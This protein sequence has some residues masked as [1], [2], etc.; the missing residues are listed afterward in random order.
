MPSVTSVMKNTV[1]PPTTTGTRAR[2]VI[3]ASRHSGLARLVVLLLFSFQLACGADPADSGDGRN[4][5]PIGIPYMVVSGE[6]LRVPVSFLH[7]SESDP[8]PYPIRRTH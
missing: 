2:L 7:E 3:S 5:A 4:G 1:V 8:G 6:Q